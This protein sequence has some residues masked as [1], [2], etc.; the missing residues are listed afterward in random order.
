[1]TFS[2]LFGLFVFIKRLVVLCFGKAQE[3]EPVC[4]TTV[5]TMFRGRGLEA[6]PEQCSIFD[7]LTRL[8]VILYVADVYLLVL[9][10]CC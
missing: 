2:T 7:K 8:T 5:L 1:M 4:R 10:Q 9:T 6:N 3:C